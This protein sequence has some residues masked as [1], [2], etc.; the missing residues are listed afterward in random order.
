VDAADG[1]GAE[2]R[3]IEQ[4][5]GSRRALLERRDLALDGRQRGLQLVEAPGIGPVVHHLHD[6]MALDEI[7]PMPP[8]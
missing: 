1:L 5:R 4:P 7:L 6:D 8:G 2:N 3:R